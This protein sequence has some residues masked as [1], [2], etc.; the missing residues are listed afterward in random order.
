MVLG[1]EKGLSEKEEQ[2]FKKAG[3]Q[4]VGL[5]RNILRSV[6]AAISSVTILGAKRFALELENTRGNSNV[7]DH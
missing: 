5:G 4:S 6:T 2:I 1:S 3:F 7:R